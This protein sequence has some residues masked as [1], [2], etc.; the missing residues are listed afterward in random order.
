MKRLVN[1]LTFSIIFGIIFTILR[2]TID[3][4]FYLP[5]MPSL[6]PIIFLS[7][8]L[9]LTILG[10]YLKNPL[11]GIIIG[12][13]SLYSK[14]LTEITKIYINGKPEI[15]LSDKIFPNLN[16]ENLNILLVPIVFSIIS[17]L[18]SY[19]KGKKGE[20]IENQ[21]VSL[22]LLLSLFLGFFLNYYYIHESIYVL[23]IASFILGLISLNTVLSVTSGI[24]FATL[25][26]F[27]NLYFYE[28]KGDINKFFENPILLLPIFLIYL[29]FTISITTFSSYP[30]YKIFSYLKERRVSGKV[31]R[32]ELLEEVEE[33]KETPALPKEEQSGNAKGG[34]DEEVR[35][36]GNL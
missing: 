22:I 10:F 18:F 13:I 25:Y 16:Y 23:P 11:F 2:N 29:I 21:F 5:L 24:F 36:D 31:V 20:K 28:F 1:G 34:L 15:L 19:V 17:F 9:I 4:Y 33:K 12:F 3:K 35:D 6:F 14:Y 30:T 8:I 26:T 27:F 32:V 7:Y